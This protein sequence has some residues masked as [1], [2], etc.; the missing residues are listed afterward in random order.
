MAWSGVALSSAETTNKAADK[1]LL[2]GL[3]AG[4]TYSAGRWVA[5]TTGVFTDT[6]ITDAQ[7]PVDL[8]FD[9]YHHARTQVDS[10][11]AGTAFSLL[12]DLGATP[13]DVDG[14]LFVDHNL[15]TTMGGGTVTAQI[16]DDSAF[17]T[18]L[19]TLASHTVTAS[20]DT[21]FAMWSLNDGTNNPARISGARY[22]R[23]TFSMSSSGAPAVGEVWLVRR[24]QLIHAPR[25]PYDD[26]G[27]MDIVTENSSGGVIFSYVDAERKAVR[28]VI[29]DNADST[30]TT[31]LEGWWDDRSGGK[32]FIWCEVPGTS[33]H[34]F[35]IMKLTN[36]RHAGPIQVGSYR[37]WSIPMTEQAPHLALES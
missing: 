2:G 17:S 6:D 11:S 35:H 4:D 14:V 28:D 9:R 31:D 27:A 37:V 22:W 32:A 20:D 18:N 15:G 34:L 19:Q 8:A 36:N 30:E 10:G 29:I 5:T 7:T 24:R 33:P 21:R 1:P 13:G 3:Q 23:F 12:A 26:T 25:M 16:A